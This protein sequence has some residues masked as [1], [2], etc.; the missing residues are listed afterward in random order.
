MKK[1]IK[2]YNIKVNLSEED[3][4][5]LQNGKEFNWNWNTEEDD[6]VII[7]LNLFQSV[8]QI[9]NLARRNK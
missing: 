8:W 5:E 9:K 2:Y 1:E 3:L 4:F 7:K 6:N